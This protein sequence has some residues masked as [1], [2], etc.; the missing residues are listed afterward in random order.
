MFLSHVMKVLQI[1][2]TTCTCIYSKP[3]LLS[4]NVNVA[5]TQWHTLYSSK[6]KKQIILYPAKCEK[7]KKSSIPQDLQK[8]STIVWKNI[9]Q[10]LRMTCNC[11]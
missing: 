11:K 9:A 4:L 7:K 2:V 5:T 3:T 8:I 6:R 1:K 10:T